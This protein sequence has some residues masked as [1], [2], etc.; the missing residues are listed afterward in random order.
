MPSVVSMCIDPAVPSSEVSDFRLLPGS[1]RSNQFLCCL[2]VAANPDGQTKRK[3]I[4][5][6]RHARF[7]ERK[8]FLEKEGILKQ[9]L[10]KR[11]W[12]P[13][14]QTSC[15]SI[16]NPNCTRQS[17]DAKRPGGSDANGNHSHLF[18]ASSPWPEAERR[19]VRSTCSSKS[20]D[21]SS[22]TCPLERTNLLNPE[23]LYGLPQAALLCQTSP[24]PICCNPAK[25]VAIDCEMVGTGP[26][27]R[28]NEMA[29]CS[30][31]NYQGL[32]IY[33]KYVKPKQPITDYR[34]RWSGIRKQHMVNAIEFNV[35]RREIL[36]ILKGKIVVGHALHNDFKAL[37]YF[38]PT[39]LVRDT[40]KIPLLK[41]K[42]GFPERE[43][44]SLKNLAK[45]LLGKSIQVG[46]DGHCSVEDAC[47]SME[48]YQQV[49]S[50]WEQKLCDQ[51]SMA[52]E[53]VASETNSEI[54]RY[55]DDQYWPT[56]LH[57]DS[58]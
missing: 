14:D 53:E 30:I 54:S 17:G 45:Q 22:K 47:T 13:L 6:R 21:Q 41:R 25:Y 46:R 27:G 31:V 23:N 36:K 38:H 10:I 4:P 24:S 29:R 48:L 5:S 40:S 39:S 34:T 11:K 57:K 7:L 33:D 42:A 32:V 2:P 58:K 43:S 16:S 1:S 44:V 49:E 52:N 35:A 8:A 20:M 55:M 51:S 28:V 19:D 12:R 9:G 50:Q 26:C 3:K 18:G 15:P 56:D 37:K